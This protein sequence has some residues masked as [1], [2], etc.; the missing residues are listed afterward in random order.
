MLLEIKVGF[1]AE[2]RR[3]VGD[4]CDRC[5]RQI[6]GAIRSGSNAFVASVATPHET[7]NDS[8][9][10]LACEESLLLRQQKAITYFSG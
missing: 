10:R 1:E 5:L 8:A 2:H 9:V 7:R 3:C 6:K 4:V